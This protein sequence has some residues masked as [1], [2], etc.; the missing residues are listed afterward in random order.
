MATRQNPNNAPVPATMIAQSHCV[1]NSTLSDIACPSLG[2]W[3]S[4]CPQRTD[5]RGIPGRRWR[6]SQA[7]V[8]PAMSD[9]RLYRGAGRTLRRLSPSLRMP[10]L[11]S[12]STPSYR[13]KSENLAGA[14]NK[15]VIPH[16]GSQWIMRQ[17]LPIGRRSSG[18]RIRRCRR[19][20]LRPS[21]SVRNP[22]RIVTEIT[23]NRNSIAIAPAKPMMNR[24]LNGRK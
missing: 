12:Q 20:Q 16:Y 14:R 23:A 11:P 1:T 17:V 18:R 10:F 4:E 6:A 2:R 3:H 5:R 19:Y 15:A 24:A 13:P 21:N 22:N 8:R 7:L 9:E